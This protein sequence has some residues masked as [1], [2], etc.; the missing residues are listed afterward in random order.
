MLSDLLQLSSAPNNILYH[1]NFIENSVQASVDPA[2]FTTAWNEPYSSGGNYW[3]D[4]NG[5]DVFS[6]P[7]QNETGSDGIGDTPY[8]MDNNNTD[9]YPLMNP[10]VLN[11]TVVF[12]GLGL[13][14]GVT[15]WVDLNGDNQSSA[16]GVISFSEPNGMYTYR[17]GASGYTASPPMGS[18]SVNGANTNEQVTFTRALNYGLIMAAIA[19]V[20]GTALIVTGFLIRRRH[21]ANDLTKP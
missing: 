14:N 15:W 10:Y 17:T 7:Y 8:I 13:S 11:Y 18:V 16:S 2:S 19:L 6:G 3:S 9:H 21:R 4:Y 5:S 12:T 20:L 1:N